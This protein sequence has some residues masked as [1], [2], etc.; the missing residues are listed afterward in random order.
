MAG[1]SR[2]QRLRALAARAG[3][4]QLDVRK[5]DAAFVHG[6]AVKERLAERSNERLEFLGDAILG[7][8]VA[9][10]LFERFPHATEGELALRKASLV[11][12]AA[13]ATTAERLDLEPL[14]FLG[15]GLAKARG[16]RR[17][18]LA[19]T[20]EALIAV[21]YRETDFETV[22]AFVEREHSAERERALS[23]LDDAK[24]VLQE[25]SQRQHAVVPVYTERAEGP[26][27]APTFISEVAVLGEILA[28]GAGPSKKE[29][30]RAAAERA[31][32]I[33]RERGAEVAEREL[34]APV[35]RAAPRRRSRTRPKRARA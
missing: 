14:L 30:Q 18:I 8:I 29:A 24:T 25:W 9:R 28:G 35:E 20:F 12:D 32:A 22:A 19:D 13:L 16:S 27:H 1:E 5:L 33:V 15:A 7:M 34:S 31:L 23:S 2:R 4:A 3:A 6:S 26:A 21:L 10:S 11:S 17:R